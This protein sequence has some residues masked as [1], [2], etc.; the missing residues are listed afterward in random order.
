[1]MR[2]G[3]FLL[4]AI[5]VYVPDTATAELDFAQQ[6]QPIF[7]EHCLKCHGPEK[8]QGGLRFDSASGALHVADSGQRA[9]VP[10]Q[11]DE[12]ELLRRVGSQDPSEWMPPEGP[13]LTDEQ[14]T[15]LRQ[16][17]KQGA[18]WPSDNADVAPLRREM[19]V[20]EADRQHWAYRPLS[21]VPLPA[22]RDASRVRTPIDCF[23]LARLEAQHL[24]P[25]APAD[26]RRLVR[27]A[28]FDLIGLPPTPQ[29]VLEFVGAARH[30]PQAAWESLIDQLLSS[31]HYGERWGR[32]WL[33][34]ARYADS[35]GQE[36]DNDRPY[37]Y[38]YRDFV[39][40]AFNDDLPFDTFIR[41]Q[42]AGDEYLP[43][44]PQAV[45]ATG[46]L[47]AGP[48]TLLD[49]PMEEEKI[50]NR[51]NELD[52]IISTLGTGLLG[53][54][55]GCAR[56]HDHKFDA[57]PTRDYYGLMAAVHS[58]DRQEVWL[59]S[60]DEI[61]SHEQALSAWESRLA[62]AQRE[63]ERWL[64]ALPPSQ[65]GAPKAARN[66]PEKRSDGE[67]RASLDGSQ[68]MEWD[69]LTQ[70]IEGIRREKPAELRR[71]LAFRDF[72]SE[73]KTTWLF[74][75]G[76]FY[77]RDQ[78][79]ALGFVTV[80]TQQKLPA[81]YWQTALSVRSRTDSTFQRRALADWITD[82]QQ[83]AG[84]L[85]ARVFVNRVWQHHFGT[86][87]VP[88]VDDFGRRGQ[89]PSHPELL[90]WLTRQF[91]RSGWRVKPLHRLIMASYTF[92]QDITYSANNTRIDADNRLLWRRRPLRL[93]AEILRDSM[94][95]VADQLNGQPYGPAFKPPIASEAFVA[96]NLKDPY[97]KDVQDSA[98]VRRRSVYMFHKRVVPYPLLQAFDRPDAQCS[99]GRRDTTTV[100]PQAL[101]LLN[102]PFV[103]QQAHS[104]A[105]RLM[106]QRA[107]DQTAQVQLAYELALARAPGQPELQAS[108]SF[109]AKRTADRTA[110]DGSTET[111]AAG[112]A[113]LA[114]FCQVLL[115]LNEFIYVD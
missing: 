34:V 42:L 58:G 12:S 2:R 48:N 66:K 39:I 65:T 44:E 57:I 38:A 108:L 63:R 26:A 81:E 15:T 6:I 78:P 55:L 88:T 22:V 46:F 106:Q 53:L 73:P 17:I 28:Y 61:A 77:D 84:V 49:V 7:R 94:L 16:W 68:Q 3:L 43:D 90:E 40:Q 31:P 54:T 112:A 5:I 29:Q 50:R 99:S 96:R 4:L 93:E 67:I 52:D 114:D 23:V 32:H 60:R 110:R 36:S 69:R 100:A 101:A 10:G 9:I 76:D 89:P 45:A 1:M 72:G 87:L 24:V 111:A 92:Q 71:A 27:R 75:R 8:T 104:F 109:L 115:G 11:P 82:T 37:A 56:C 103:R 41:W 85:L 33:D 18:V 74:E 105:A 113:A 80:L 21:D 79:I 20:T 14:L 51:Y 59:G 83:G 86:G 19:V 62:D 13:R 64:E 107:N 70:Q 102:D 35:N 91:V 97:P 98:A 95:A 30:D 25:T 47:T